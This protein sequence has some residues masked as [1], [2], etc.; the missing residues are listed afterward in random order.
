MKKYI[1]AT[2]VF[3]FGLVLL[4]QLGAF[5]VAEVNFMGTLNVF[6]ATEN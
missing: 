1:I 5:E 2:G 3:I 6:G 4:N